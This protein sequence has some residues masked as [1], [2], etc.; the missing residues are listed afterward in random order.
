MHVYSNMSP[1]SLPLHILCSTYKHGLQKLQAADE[2]HTL[3]TCGRLCAQEWSRCQGSQPQPVELE[4]CVELYDSLGLCLHMH[5]CTPP[6]QYISA[7]WTIHLYRYFLAMG[8][9]VHTLQPVS[10]VF[11]FLRGLQV[12]PVYILPHHKSALSLIATLKFVHAS[13]VRQS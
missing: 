11:N 5:V 3:S 6:Q 7:S 1:F 4:W 2:V 9:K 8:I 10:T 12:H 13:S